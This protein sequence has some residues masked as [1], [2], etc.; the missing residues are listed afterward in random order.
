[1]EHLILFQRPHALF[2][3]DT[4]EMVASQAD[5]RHDGWYFIAFGIPYRVRKLCKGWRMYRWTL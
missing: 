5:G 3:W 4:E 2:V 1:M